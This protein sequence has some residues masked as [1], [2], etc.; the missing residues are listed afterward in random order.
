MPNAVLERIDS[1]G[2]EVVALQRA[3]VAIPALGPDNDGQGETAKA[4]FLERHLRA[5]G[6]TDILRLDAPD[7]RVP[8]GL[9]PNILA[10]IPGRD[11]ARTLWIISH[12]DI[13]PPG[14]PELWESDPYELKVD[15]DILVGRGVEDNHGGIVPSLVLA[16]ALLDAGATPPMNLGLLLVADEE[17]GSAYGLG[18]VVAEHAEQFGPDDLF[19]VPDFGVP[20]SSLME[21]A[22]KSMLWLKV[23]VFGR[24]CHASTPEQGV[25]TLVAAADFILRTRRLHEEFPATDPLFSPAHSTF[26]PTRKD[27]NVPNVNTIPGHDVFYVDCRVLPGYAVAD[28]LDAFGRIAAEIEAEHGVRIVRT[29]IQSEQAAPATPVDSEIVR[30]LSA[31]IQAVYGVTPAPAGI[32]GGTVAAILRRAGRDAVVWSTC[33][34]FAHQPNERSRISTQLGDAKVMARVLFA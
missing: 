5:L 31:A 11:T 7:A 13:V 16:K 19:L 20:D 15:G 2:P 30:R 33:E 25:N 34:H 17:T 23:E 6:L 3:L 10:R 28:V 29:P 8:G 12:I 4:D 1:L 9:R 21:V 26:S 18:H 24:Q 14:N 32:G 27:A 22:E